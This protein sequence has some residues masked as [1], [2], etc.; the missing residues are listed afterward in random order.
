MEK[1]ETIHSEAEYDAALARISKLMDALSG[2]EGQIADKNH[3]ARVELDSLVDQ[4]ERYEDLHYPI[5]PRTLSAAIKF[6]VEQSGTSP[7]DLHHLTE[8]RDKAT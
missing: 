4:V 7:T 8:K 1:T 2:P 5:D 3:P 6:H